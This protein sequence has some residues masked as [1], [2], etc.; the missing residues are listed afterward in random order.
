VTRPLKKYI[1]KNQRKGDV[2]RV[3][4]E[5][6]QLEEGRISRYE[7]Q[8]SESDSKNGRSELSC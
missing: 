2:D 6:Q 7:G 8:K 1:A 5:L 3:L 4:K